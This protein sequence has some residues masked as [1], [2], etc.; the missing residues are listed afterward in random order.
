MMKTNLYQFVF[1]TYTA[2][3]AL[4]EA[5]AILLNKARQVAIQAYA[6]YS[7][8][9]VGAA[10]LLTNGEIVVGTNQENASFPAGICAER[11]LLSTA[12]SLYP[13]IP[14]QTIAISYINQ[15]GESKHPI[16]PC[17][18]CR[19]SMLEYEIKQKQP[20]RL[21]LSGQEGLV[22]V[23]PQVACLLPLSFTGDDL[24]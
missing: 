24:G 1:D 3:S 15:Q 11:C 10:G 4:T 17:G 9:F 6:P 21:I 12:A 5:D 23:I 8:F 22:Y 14:I 16:S 18:I 13:N 19:Q 7:Q 20:I 2:A